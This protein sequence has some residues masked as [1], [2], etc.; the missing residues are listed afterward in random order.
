MRNFSRITNY[1]NNIEARHDWQRWNNLVSAIFPDLPAP[2]TP[3]PEAS[4]RKIDKA[5]EKLRTE[6]VRR[7]AAK[8]EL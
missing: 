6:F 8:V 2:F 3:Q 1:Y 4:W 7:L 5:I